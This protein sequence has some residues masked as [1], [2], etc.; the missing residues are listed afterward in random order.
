MSK[1]AETKA[2]PEA[3][4]A[5]TVR[6][7]VLVHRLRVGDFI[8]AEGAEI[9]ALPLDEFELRKAAGELQLIAIN[10]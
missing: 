6:A 8:H 7:L 5:K 1:T 10:P 3:A 2:A 9:P 4:P